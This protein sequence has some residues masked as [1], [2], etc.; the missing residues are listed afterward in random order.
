MRVFEMSTFNFK[1]KNVRGFEVVEITSVNMYL[2]C[3]KQRLN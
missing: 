2:N 1:L 3:G